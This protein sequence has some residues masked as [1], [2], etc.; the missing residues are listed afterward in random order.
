[1]NEII[2]N[3]LHVAPL[4]IMAVL[5]IIKQLW[6][7]NQFLN[8]VRKNLIS[9]QL[10]LISVG[11]LSGTIFHSHEGILGCNICSIYSALLALIAIRLLHTN[12][13]KLKYKAK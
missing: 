5:A 11:I 13:N 10:L 8:H 1:M 3:Y 6:P 9:I 4:L 7:E 2:I 12:T